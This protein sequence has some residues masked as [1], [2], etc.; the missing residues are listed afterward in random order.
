MDPMVALD[1]AVKSKLE[2]AF[3][4]GIAM[5]IVA[6]ASND[7]HTPIIGLSKNDYRRLVETICCDPRVKEMWG[8]AG[9][10]TQLDEWLKLID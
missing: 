8:E 7:A 1:T 6:N 10:Q 3:G 2:D 9:T 4:K 5:L